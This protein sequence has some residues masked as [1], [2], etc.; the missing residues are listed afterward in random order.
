[1]SW[2]DISWP[3]MGGACLTLGL[4][5]LLVWFRR[6][7]HKLHLVF[8]LAS[9]SVA[10]ISA[11]ELMM[12]HARDTMHYAE[13]LRWAHVP[14]AIMFSMLA[15]FVHLQFSGS[16][17]WLCAAVCI[18][19]AV[20]LL[21]NF[22]TGVNIN[23]VEVNELRFME[24]WGGM[25]AAIP[26]GTVNPWMAI[27]QL[28]IYLFIIYVLD[29]MLRTWRDA[30][31]AER[32]RAIRVCGGIALFA[33]MVNAWRVSVV[34]GWISAPDILVPTFLCVI[35]VMSNELGGDILRS[36]QLSQNLSVTEAKLRDS[37][38]RM[39]VAV[40]AGE[41]GL[42]SW[43][44]DEEKFWF[45]DLSLKLLG[46]APDTKFDRKEFIERIQPADREALIHA[47]IEATRNEGDFRSEYRIRGDDGRV[48]FIAVRGQMEF[49][50]NGA[51][52]RLHGVLADVTE[53]K[54]QQERFH[55]AVEASPTA[56]LMT[57]AEGVVSLAN[58]Q[59]EIVFGYTRSELLGLNVD[60][61]V[62]DRHRERHAANR[63]MYSATASARMMGAGRELFGRRKD[64]SE[65]PVE[66]ALNPIHV[67]DSLHVLVS[68]A[69][70]SERRRLERESAKHRD[71]LAHLSRVALLAE[72]SGSLAHELNQPLTAILS[73]AQAATRFMAMDPP[74]LDEVRESLINIVESDKRAG[75]VIRR[76][77]A[78][79]R[80]EAP[81]HREV[82]LNEIVLDVLRIIRSDLLN[83]NT[84]TVL[85]MQ[86]NLPVVFGDRVQL[87][88]VLL[89]LVMNGCDAMAELPEGR[90]LVL[91]TAAAADGGVLV[92]VEDVGRGIPPED[93]ERIFS[94]FV[95]SKADG[96]GLGLAVCT[97]ILESHH[98][99]L[100]ATNNPHRGASF[101]FR[102]PPRDGPMHAG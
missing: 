9:I 25:D 38:A 60:A 42:W 33:V 43:G 80:K 52:I 26:V 84:E 22:T 77:R 55:L 41:M 69:D 78:M 19:R 83:R 62:P 81:E 76:L 101:H 95:S 36:A 73:N 99:K 75:E 56:M 54:Q 64:G 98:G 82:D 65:V 57:G 91:R 68:I 97:T 18:G 49:E 72:L 45:T 34:M 31:P 74:N 13:L 58:R 16:R 63:A 50:R 90:R 67:G 86:P 28:G 89:N 93:L 70:I 14:G 11:F 46:F 40:R 79:L 5:H 87:Q 15:L 8:A 3:L 35:F 12:M 94:P 59:A 71:E 47:F 44:I 24:V 30:K 100:W 48:R 51:P 20:A 17:A 85:E 23:Y 66:I 37:E 10:A 2:I 96:M 27:G 92:S 4:I 88:Q 1:M 39:D 32:W 29:T 61:L 102:L 53:R 7:D 21:L 6:R